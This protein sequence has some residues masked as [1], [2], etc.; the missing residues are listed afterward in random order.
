MN[1]L[2]PQKQH[3]E[4][5]ALIRL[6]RVLHWITVAPAALLVVWSVSS[7]GS[8][9]DWYAPA[10]TAILPLMLGRGLRYILANE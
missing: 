9:S 8:E 7:I 1:W 6:G 5:T 3:A 4:T 10:L 2:W